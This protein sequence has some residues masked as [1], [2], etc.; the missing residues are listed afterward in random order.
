MT[1]DLPDNT[2]IRLVAVHKK[3]L[4]KY[5]IIVTFYEYKSLYKKK[6]YFYYAYQV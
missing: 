5:E 4:K 2:P 6:E 3:T 1:Y